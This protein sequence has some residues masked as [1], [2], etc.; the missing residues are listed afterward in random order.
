MSSM[1]D[2]E[3]AIRRRLRDDFEHYAAKCLRIRTKAGGTEPFVL[4][5]SQPHLKLFGLALVGRYQLDLNVSHR[6]EQF[7][8]VEFQHSAL[9]L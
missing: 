6:K 1:T 9:C 5:R 7:S 3:K 4:N 2:R 8:A